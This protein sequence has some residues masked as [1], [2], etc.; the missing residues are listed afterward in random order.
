MMEHTKWL[1]VSRQNGG[2]EKF[3]EKWILVCL[4]VCLR[5]YVH[6]YL[7]AASLWTNTAFETP[8]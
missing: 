8:I 3:V 7:G 6:S 2:S 5:V 1:S 4:C